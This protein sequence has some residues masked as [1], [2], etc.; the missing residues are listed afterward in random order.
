MWLALGTL[1][2]ELRD[3]EV[4]VGSGADADWRVPAA[5]LMARHFLVTVYDLNASLRPFGT[6]AVVVVNGT[7]IVGTAHLLIDGDVIEA[8]SGRFAFSEDVPRPAH[9]EGPIAGATEAA[10]RFLVDEDANVAYQLTSR[11]TPIGRD[12][13][14][15]II[16]REPTA[17]RFHAEV[18]R[19]AGGFALHSMGSAGTTINGARMTGPRLLVDGDVV[20]IARTSLRFASAVE[21]G[22]RIASSAA[23]GDEGARTRPTE[24]TPRV[25]DDAMR[26]PWH[27]LSPMIVA[28]VVIA[29]FLAL[30]AFF[31]RH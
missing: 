19:E 23:A 30:W 9:G 18:R 12:A 22:T 15:N 27:S 3:G 11:S 1:T 28:F 25:A 4:I 26:L 14:N 7:Q 17:S 16:I 24:L 8:G 6:D 20:G 2:K 13:S 21:A 10:P 29:L 31:V 5:D